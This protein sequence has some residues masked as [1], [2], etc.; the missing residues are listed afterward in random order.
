M[1]A[2]KPIPYSYFKHNPVLILVHMTEKTN[3][4]CE[5]FSMFAK[6]YKMSFVWKDSNVLHVLHSLQNF[7]KYWEILKI[8]ASIIFRMEPSTLL[9]WNDPLFFDRRPVRKQSYCACVKTHRVQLTECVHALHCT[10][11][12][13]RPRWYTHVPMCTTSVLHDRST[14]VDVCQQCSSV[15]THVFIISSVDISTHNS[16][17]LMSVLLQN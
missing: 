16:E 6:Y 2:G 4:P 3:I 15:F 17:M 7:C 14:F 8:L 12:G 13:G 11:S 10:T 5:I 1:D 9:V